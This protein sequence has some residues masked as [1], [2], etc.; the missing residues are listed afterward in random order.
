LLASKEDIASALTEWQLRQEEI[1]ARKEEKKKARKAI[2][3]V[4]KAEKEDKPKPKKGAK[5]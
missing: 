5:K 1:R 2:R 3:A 4:A